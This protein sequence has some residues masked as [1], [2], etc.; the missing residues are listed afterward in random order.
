VIAASSQFC[1]AA[2]IHHLHGPRTIGGS[3]IPQ[4]NAPTPTTDGPVN[5][6][7]TGVVLTSRDLERTCDA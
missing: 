4:R 2:Q 3:I 5:E 6:Q 1:H 7:H